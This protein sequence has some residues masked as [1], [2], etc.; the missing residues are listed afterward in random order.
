MENSGIVEINERLSKVET[1]LSW[2][3][4]IGA[5]IG[6]AVVGI[7]IWIGSLIRDFIQVYLNS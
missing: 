7:L 6:S 2:M 4:K 3:Y 5:V 1:S